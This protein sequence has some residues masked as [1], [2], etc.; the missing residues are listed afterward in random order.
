MNKVLIAN[1]GEI[2]V[3]I[4]RACRDLGISTVA[5]YADCDINALHVQMADEAWSLPG[6]RPEETYL[7]IE[8]I[9]GI[10]QKAKADAIHPGY[11]FLSERADF[12]QAALDAGLCWIGPSPEAIDMLGDKVKARQLAKSVGAPLVAG[13]QDPVSSA[14][15]VLKFAEQYGL[16]LVI[17]AAYGG[18]GRG[19]KVVWR[20]DDIPELYASAVREAVAAFG[21]GECFVEQFLDR[22]RHIEAQVLAD[23][24]GNV[25]VLGTRDCSLQRRN[26]K[27]IEE[28]PAPFLSDEQRQ[29]IHDAARALCR[30]AAY[31]GAGTVEF[32]L[33]PEGV[34]SFLEVNTRLQVEHTVTEET[35]G[36]DLVIAQLEIARGKRLDNTETPP[37]HG[38]AFEFR[39]NAEDPAR[40]FLPVSGTISDFSPPSGIGIRLDSGVRT[41]S[42]VPP[43]FDSLLA[44]L[45]VWGPSREMALA[46]ARR[47][48]AEFKIEGLASVLPFH[49]AALLAPDFITAPF[50]VHTRWIETDF[51]VDLPLADRTLPAQEQSLTRV[52]IELDGKRVELGLPDSLLAGVTQP[53]A[54]PSASLVV[55]AGAVEAPISGVLLSWHVEE[56]QQVSEGDPIAMMEAMKMETP[57]YAHCAGRITLRAAAGEMVTAGAMLA[58]IHRDA[59]STAS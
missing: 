44:K 31:C 20:R 55:N 13:T 5:V 22:P 41:G 53:D 7:C 57:L 33:S 49:R 4:I 16:P 9:L 8:K 25:Q 35:T 12:A 2:A 27:L 59:D 18:G 40:G 51:G 43:T 32:L 37:P 48:L 42:T 39:I 52:W 11:G 26:Q 50:S 54:Q 6:N 34:I 14:D 46:R 3:R 15:D 1:R 38:H 29:R 24:Y 19:M 58:D 36:I 45:I 23:N 47:A 10:A 21:R 30:E 28:A 17:K 56:G